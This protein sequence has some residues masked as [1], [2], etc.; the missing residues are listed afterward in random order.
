ML[1]VR[2]FGK[3]ATFRLILYLGLGYSILNAYELETR[4]IIRRRGKKTAVQIFKFVQK[5]RKLVKSKKY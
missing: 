2:H 5:S 4:I 1:L 3:W